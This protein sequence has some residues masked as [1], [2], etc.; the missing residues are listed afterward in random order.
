MAAGL[1]AA[2]LVAAG[3]LAW[4]AYNSPPR[5]ADALA[6]SFRAS[7]AR[8][9]SG[10]ELRDR[11]RHA[12][13]AALYR[14]A[15]Q[16]EPYCL[17]CYEHLGGASADAGDEVG[18]EAAYREAAR[19]APTV[20]AYQHGLGEALFKQ[21][22]YREAAAAF[23]EAVRLAPNE[24]DYHYKLGESFNN[25]PDR[26]ESSK[27]AEYEYREAIR[28]GPDRHEYHYGRGRALHMLLHFTDAAS[29]FRKALELLPPGPDSDK[30]RSEYQKRLAGSS[31]T[32]YG[33]TARKPEL[34]SKSC[35]GN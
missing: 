15:G 18:A 26:P 22:K 25:P 5:E 20:A 27:C 31:G 34:A 24:A 29:E 23:G 12:E 19:L 3:A 28:L 7:R 13:A 11:G 1:L 10:D 6:A 16:L 2:V 4:S 35:A 9:L 17:E 8:R 33:D 30:L 32:D 14:E 21:G